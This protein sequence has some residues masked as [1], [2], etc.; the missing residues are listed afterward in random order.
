VVDGKIQWIIDGYTTINNYPYAQQTQLGEATNDSLT[1]VAKQANSSINYIRNSVKATVDAFNGT[2][3]L[4]SIDDKEPVLNAWEKVFPGLV[5]P[6]SAIS[7]D[8]R[9]HFRYPEDLFKVQ[10]ELLAKYHV[11][12]PQ[13]F[14]AQQAFWSVPQDPTQ[15]GGANAN[16]AGVANQPGYYVLADT[17]GEKKTTFQ[18]TS[19]LTGLQRQ[20]LAAW[21]SV[22]SDPADYG[23]I[24]VL[25]LPASAAGA[26]QVDGPV[27]VQ[28]RFQSDS[29]FASERT[30]FT[31]QSVTVIFG[32]LITLP[33]A[34]GFLY[35]EPVYIRQKNQNSYPQLARVLVAFGPKIGFDSTL[36]GALD[37]V[38]GPGTGDTTASPTQPPTGPTATSPPTTPGGTGGNAAL[39]KAAA[40]IQNAIDQYQAAMQSGNFA[41]QGAALQALDTATK[42]YSAALAAAGAS[43]TPTST[44]GAPTSQPGG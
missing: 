7:P 44:P 40:D 43:T 14:Y 10:R 22:S 29:R 28:N 20:Y 13:E 37:Q 1:G 19:P 31:N 16:A 39:N 30:L 18:L 9:S 3:T 17:P 35:V 41:N 15:E 21:V 27:Q 8:L 34:D 24:R 11:H 5:K 23:T 33:V 4:Y 12:D 25:Q 42:A 26:S 6:S 2:V 36:K 32:N 38:F